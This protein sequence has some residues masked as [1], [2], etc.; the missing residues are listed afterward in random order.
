VNARGGFDPTEGPLVSLV[1]RQNAV[2]AVG[3]LHV[4]L[5]TLLYNAG[6]LQEVVGKIDGPGS[7]A[8][9]AA[10]AE[11]VREMSIEMERVTRAAAEADAVL[12]K[13]PD[14]QRLPPVDVDGITF[15]HN[16]E[17]VP[18]STP[19]QLEAD[20]NQLEALLAMVRDRP[21][22]ASD[23]PQVLTLLRAK[24]AACVDEFTSTAAA[25]Q[26]ASTTR[27]EWLVR[28]E[29]ARRGRRPAT[30]SAWSSSSSSS[31]ATAATATTPA[32][33]SLQPQRPRSSRSSRSRDT[34]RQPGS[35]PQHAVAQ[36]PIP[37]GGVS[38]AITPILERSRA[39]RA[40]AARV[41]G[42]GNTTVDADLSSAT[43]AAPEQHSTTGSTYA[44]EA[45]A[46][47]GAGT[48]A[49]LALPATTPATGAISKRLARRLMRQESES[50]QRSQGDALAALGSAESA[51]TL[52]PASAA[53][54]ATA[55]AAALAPR[56]SSSSAAA[57]SDRQPADDRNG[58]SA[59][60]AGISDAD[61]ESALASGRADV[62]LRHKPLAPEQVRTVA[63]SLRRA[64]TLATLDLTH[65]KVGDAGG[66][67]IASIIEHN[68]TL[69]R[70]Y[71]GDNDL[72]AQSGSALG[73]AIVLTGTLEHWDV[74]WNEA[75]AMDPV[76]AGLCGNKSLRSI[77]VSGT[78][79]ASATSSTLAD[80]LATNRSLTTVTA[81]YCTISEAAARE[82]ARSLEAS[83]AT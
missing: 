64:R 48:G 32:S 31:A 79:V 26:N 43:A 68:T 54:S 83:A 76:C 37:T 25:A 22:P 66:V 58:N 75:L 78:P 51:A 65:C 60:D 46:G 30:A 72:G 56:Q 81:T 39:A 11:A 49:G 4:N 69:R 23:A 80:V 2:H 3:A 14:I 63:A 8:T 16:H 73:N 67:L 61:L 77:D 82:I 29:T 5:R 7:P 13:F 33:H 55:L 41:A 15:A 9:R 27:A 18:I 17:R 50:Q 6:L 10:V 34:S 35:P 45:G 71:I 59:A 47:A 20:R 1:P 53:V 42:G 12:A 70:L 28:G 38:D 44:A 62:S 40:A 36:P 52:A 19:P 21:L 24:M 74:S 57:S